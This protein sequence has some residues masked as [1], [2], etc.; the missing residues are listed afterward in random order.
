MQGVGYKI[1][2]DK[3]HFEIYKSYDRTK[4]KRVKSNLK[5]LEF[6][7]LHELPHENQENSLRFQDTLISF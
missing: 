2:V 4:K 6:E 5:I 1:S 7:I 3:S